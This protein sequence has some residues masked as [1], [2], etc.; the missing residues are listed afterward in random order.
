MRKTLTKHIPKC[1][2]CETKID[3][4]ADKAYCFHTP[5]G[6]MY[7]CGPCVAIVY[8]QHIKDLPPYEE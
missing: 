5:E 3:L 6:E 1:D 4:K 7:I 2:R 8:N